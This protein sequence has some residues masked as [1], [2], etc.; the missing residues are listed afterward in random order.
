MLERTHL[1]FRS[2]SLPL[3]A[4]T[5]LVSRNFIQQPYNYN[6][7]IKINK[8]EYEIFP[9]DFE[10]N[11]KVLDFYQN[12]IFEKRKSE[13]NN[14]QKNFSIYYIVDGMING[15]G[16]YSILTESLGEY[17]NDYL[18]LLNETKNKNDYQDFEKIVKIFNDYK[19]SFLEQEI[20]EELEEDEELCESIDEIE[21][22]WYD[23]SEIRENT[24]FDYLKKNKDKIITY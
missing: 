23:N 15:S 4:N 13:L 9:E 1:N 24:F 22:R 18:E 19:E 10:I 11:M 8:K 14:V 2:T 20:P 12:F 17:N 7:R 6:E 3:F 16:I 21:N 5:R